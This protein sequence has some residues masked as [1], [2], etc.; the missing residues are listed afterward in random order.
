VSWVDPLHACRGFSREDLWGLG[1][2]CMNKLEFSGGTEPVVM[3]VGRQ[4]HLHWTVVSGPPQTTVM[5]R[6]LEVPPQEIF[7]QLISQ[8]WWH[9]IDSSPPTRRTAQHHSAG[10][11]CLCSESI[12]GNIVPLPTNMLLLGKHRA[13]LSAPVRHQNALIGW[14]HRWAWQP[15]VGGIRS[16]TAIFLRTAFA[17]VFLMDSSLE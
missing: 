2:G 10:S 11:G 9:R 6:A 13:P 3:Y 16:L 12:L 8:P 1:E 15:F 17:P 14:H 5:E 4:I 7:S